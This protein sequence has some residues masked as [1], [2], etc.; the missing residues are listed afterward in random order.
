TALVCDVRALFKEKPAGLL[1]LSADERERLWGELSGPDGGRAFR[2]ISRLAAS[3]PEGVAFLETRL[4]APPKVGPQHLARLM[5]AL[6]DESFEAREKASDELERLGVLAEAAVRDA[7]KAGPS[8]EARVR[9]E[10][11][12]ERLKPAPSPELVALRA[13]EALERN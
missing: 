12:L 6:D 8:A 1:K 4:K 9:L 7:L 10:R 3:G 13:V 5:K 11:L 2:A